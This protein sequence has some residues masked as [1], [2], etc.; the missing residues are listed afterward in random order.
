M[1]LQPWKAVGGRNH[2]M[3]NDKAIG[4][5]IENIRTTEVGGREG[6]DEISKELEDRTDREG[7]DLRQN[8]E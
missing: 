7:E 3:G 6:V 1:A 2:G 8:Q 5:L 4:P